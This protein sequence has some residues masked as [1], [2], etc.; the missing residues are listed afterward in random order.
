MS[1][2]AFSDADLLA[3]RQQNKT[4]VT[5]SWAKHSEAAKQAVASP[6]GPEKDRLGRL[7]YAA[8]KDYA[9]FMPMQALN[10]PMHG[11]GWTSG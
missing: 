11:Y 7:A 8:Y 10:T 9:D 5:E 2:G 3:L 4:A 6:E 1:G